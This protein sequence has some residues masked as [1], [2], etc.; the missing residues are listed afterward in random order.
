MMIIENDSTCHLGRDVISHDEPETWNM[1]TVTWR[2]NPPKQQQH[3]YERVLSFDPHP[4][5]KLLHSVSRS[6]WLAKQPFITLRH[7]EWQGR[8]EGMPRHRGQY[9]WRISPR[10]HSES[11]VSWKTA[12]GQKSQGE[13]KKY[14]GNSDH[15]KATTHLCCFVN[16]IPTGSQALWQRSGCDESPRHLSLKGKRTQKH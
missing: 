6:A 1:S 12:E 4:P 5:M 16:N 2:L 14:D 7:R 3:V 11:A 9:H 15:L 13:E 8:R 10:T